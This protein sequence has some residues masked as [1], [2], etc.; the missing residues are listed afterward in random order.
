VSGPWSVRK[1]VTVG[2]VVVL[3]IPVVVVTGGAALIFAYLFG[4]YH[5]GMFYSGDGEYRK[6]VD[7]AAFQVSFPDVDLSKAGRSTFHFARLGPEMDYA[8]GLRIP[9]PSRAVV[10][11]TMTNERGEIV[12]HQNRPLA[13]W[14]WHRD[15]AVIDGITDDIPI[16]GGSVRIQPRDVGPD[17]GWGTH[18]EPRWS[19]HYA[20]TIDVVEPDPTRVVARPVIEGYMAWF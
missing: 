12:F 4:Y 2:A 11:M 9:T 14:R 15:L 8:V 10:A 5:A 7:G 16:G 17:G 3:A 13:Q 18:F 6:G 19:G 20:L 1:R